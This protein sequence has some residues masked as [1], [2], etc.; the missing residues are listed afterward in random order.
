MTNCTPDNSTSENRPRVSVV[1]PC[2]NQGQFIDEA[3]E[4]V[5]KQTFQDFEIIVVNDGS[6]DG[7][8]SELLNSYN[9]PKTTVHKIR[10]SGVPA[11]RNYGVKRSRGEYF[12][13]LDADDKIAPEFLEKCVLELDQN[14]ELG[15]VYTY[16]VC[17]GTEDGKWRFK[18]FDERELLL[19]NIVCVSSLV[20]RRAFDDA[21]GYNEQ[22]RQGYE[23]WDFWIGLVEK[24]WHGRRIPEHL[25]YYRKHP[26]S[27]CS[28][29]DLPHNRIRLIERICRNHPEIYRANLSYVVSEKEKMIL[30]NDARI[31]LFERRNSALLGS[32]YWRVRTKIRKFCFRLLRVSS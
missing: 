6:T 21:G 27:M 3:V 32:L 18:R 12:L 20:R 19:H 5:L 17:F 10:N 31:K 1:I 29:S 7:F 11:A 25:F 23:D 14:P 2:Y 16:L 8:T 24:G 26:G 28:V 9:R 4:S 22:M 15:F 13:P 30:M